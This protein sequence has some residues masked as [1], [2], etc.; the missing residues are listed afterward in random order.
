MFRANDHVHH[1]PTGED[2]TLACDEQDGEII[3]CG[4][5]ET[6]ARASDCTLIQ[7]TTDAGRLRMLAQVARSCHDQTRGSRAALQLATGKGGAS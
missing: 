6:M 5:P 1:G 7:A 2:W 3:C 4:W